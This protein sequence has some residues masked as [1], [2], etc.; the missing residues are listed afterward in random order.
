VTVT[1]TLPAPPTPHLGVRPR[2]AT[3]DAACGRCRRHRAVAIGSGFGGMT[4]TKA[5]KHSQINLT[6]VLV[7]LSRLTAQATS[8]VITPTSLMAEV[9][10]ATAVTATF[11]VYIALSATA[12]VQYVKR[13]AAQAHLRWMPTTFS[14]PSVAVMTIKSRCGS[15]SAT[16]ASEVSHSRQRAQIS[17][18]AHQNAPAQG[19]SNCYRGSRRTVE[20]RR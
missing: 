17:I 3:R 8:R 19:D 7:F 16:T 18:G 5:L 1:I 14:G 2:P 6:D 11:S 13:I 10:T 15:A 4:A 9:I 20:G 12:I